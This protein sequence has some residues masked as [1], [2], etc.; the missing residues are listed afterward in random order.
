M[1][2]DISFFLKLST[3]PEAPERIVLVAL[4]GVLEVV[5][6]LV[7]MWIGINVVSEIVN[8]TVSEREKSLC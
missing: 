3:G 5:L 7:N 8:E 2:F 6:V 1:K 4:V